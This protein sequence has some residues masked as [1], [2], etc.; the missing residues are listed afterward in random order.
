MGPRSECTIAEIVGKAWHSVYGERL[1]ASYA[2][3]S[4]TVWKVWSELPPAHKGL[5]CSQYEQHHC[6]LMT[7]DELQNEIKVYF[8]TNLFYLSKGIFAIQSNT[9]NRK[10][11]FTKF[12]I[13]DFDCTGIPDDTWFYHITDV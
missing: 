1:P 7:S 10:F 11:T 12:F 6:Y 5:S 8:V 3:I 9:G 13:S 4:N 2:E